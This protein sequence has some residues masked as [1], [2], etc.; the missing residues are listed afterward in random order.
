MP[1]FEPAAKKIDPMRCMGDWYVQSGVAILGAERTGF[2]HLE[3]YEWD[4]ANSRVNVAYSF[5]EMSPTGKVNA[6]TQI[7]RVK[8]GDD[9]GTHWQVKPLIGCIRVPVWLDYYIV[10]VDTENYEWIVAAAPSGW[11]IY[12]MTRTKCVDDAVLAPHHELLR[13]KGVNMAKVTRFNQSGAAD[14][15]ALPV[16]PT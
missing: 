7:G 10:D 3:Q 2:N 4:A 8:P 12:I 5:N 16:A 1:K 9:N 15:H 13:S 11:W 6:S 14:A